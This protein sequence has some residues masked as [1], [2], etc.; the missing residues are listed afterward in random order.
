MS[1]KN[2]KVSQKSIDP[3]EFFNLTWYDPYWELR[4]F[5]KREE[6]TTFITDTPEPS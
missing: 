5:P 4:N 2:Q 6:A 1:S 3:W